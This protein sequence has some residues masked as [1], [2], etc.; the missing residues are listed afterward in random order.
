MM[1]RH[2]S[3]A[4]PIETKDNHQECT[5]VA[6][7]FIFESERNRLPGAFC[8][9]HQSVDS[10]EENSS[11]LPARNP[12]PMA[13]TPVTGGS[14]LSTF[15]PVLTLDGFAWCF[16][17]DHDSLAAIE[18]EVDTISTADSHKW[19]N[20]Y[21]FN[22]AVLSDVIASIVQ[23]HP[24]ELRDLTPLLHQG[25]ALIV[26]APYTQR[27]RSEQKSWDPAP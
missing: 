9:V 11:S 26:A 20:I 3:H 12:V 10:D 16:Q 5:C 25:E 1:A 8:D 19:R 13:R 15:L 6:V 4:E 22:S 27:S 21:R 7:T 24:D 18:R 14:N 17:L 2:G 23:N